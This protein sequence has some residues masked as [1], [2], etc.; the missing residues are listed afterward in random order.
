MDRRGFL[1][2]LG[3]VAALPVLG[4]YF[5][6]AKPASK[7]LEAVPKFLSEQG[8]PSFFY[9]LV[10]GVKKFGKPTKSTRDYTA[11]EYTHPVTKQ[12]VKVVDGR[13]DVAIGFET[14]RG[15]QAEMGVRKGIP[16]EVTKGKTPPDEYY[17]G[18]QVYE[19]MGPNDYTKDWKEEISGGYKGLEELANKLKRHLREPKAGGGAVG[20]PP[21]S[22]DGFQ[23]SD[24]KEAAKM[25]IKSMLSSPNGVE[26]IPIYSGNNFTVEGGFGMGAQKPFDYG[27]NFQRGDLGVSAMMNQGRPMFGIDYNPSDNFSAGATFGNGKP[28]FGFNFRKEFANGGLTDTIPPKRGPMS[29]G[30]ES[31]FRKR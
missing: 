28:S 24:P 8:M 29:E 12:K 15:F 30:V 3:G 18:E 9:D 17:E 5:K 19:F 2:L 21:V 20:M 14:D 6:F 11:Y 4:K 22:E 10:A 23:T 26:T 16:D 31:L 1:K 27:I 13:E 7:T 25:I